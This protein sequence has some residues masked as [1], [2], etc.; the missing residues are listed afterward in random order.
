MQSRFFCWSDV[1][2][3]RQEP[4][5][6]TSPLL[7]KTTPIH[8]PSVS[9]TCYSRH[10]EMT[11]HFSGLWSTLSDTDKVEMNVGRTQ[12]NNLHCFCPILAD[13]DQQTVVGLQHNGLYPLYD[14]IEDWRLCLGC[15]TTPIHQTFCPSL[16]WHVLT[17]SQASLL[18]LPDLCP[19]S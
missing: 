1:C 2:E 16:F 15:F 11:L 17:S 7:T 10:Q 6:D 12:K 18:L 13:F 14:I 9:S 3:H 19:C 5:D 8:Q 4:G